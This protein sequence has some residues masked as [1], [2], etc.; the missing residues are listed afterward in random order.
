MENARVRKI[1]HLDLD[2]FFCAVEEL[3]DPSLAGKAF[4]V[5]GSAG[6]RGVI[7]SCSYP[8]RKAGVHSAM[9]TGQALRLCPDLILI[10]GG[11]ADYSAKSAEVMAILRNLSGMVEQV[12][13]DEAFID[14]TDLPDSPEAIARHLQA[15]VRKKTGL[16]CS[17]GAAANKLVAK[18]A[19]DQ[20]KA[21]SRTGSYPCAILV[22][23]PG[24][25]AAF[26][27]PL[28]T[29]AM[30]GVGPKL[31]AA[32][33]AAGM[34]TLGDVAA[35][36][37]RDLERLFGKYGADLHAHALGIDN[38]PLT[39]AHEAKSV[40]QETTFARDVAD[41]QQLRQTL[42]ELSATV[43]Y[44][45]R[46]DDVCAR[47]VRLKIR[48]SDFST[49]T[50]QERLETPTDQDGVIFAVAEK[51]WRA[52]WTDGRP[53]RLIGVGGADLVE[54]AHQMSLWD[55]STEKERK[56]HEALDSLNERYGRQA[57]RKA[58]RLKNRIT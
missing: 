25:E 6:R 23:P 10:S 32:L 21:R 3:K 19:T 42:R 11:Y 54:T 43:A 15:E 5:G 48:W 27:A 31:A 47:V 49:H 18:V 58:S 44:R 35:R 16:P 37:P 1:L 36:D 7:S 14:V 28:K 51:L 57:V 26:L 56:L 2:A 8:A 50:R 12:S 45:L 39:L 13:V 41:P 33:S 34:A 29:S 24:Q 20:G 38:R 40:S 52:I 53:V 4:A 17:I 22:V 55:V 30:W 46:K 9:P